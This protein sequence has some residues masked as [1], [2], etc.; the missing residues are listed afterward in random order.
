L[1]SGITG[2]EKGVDVYYAIAASNGN[3]TVT[4][5][6]ASTTYKTGFVS[7]WSAPAVDLTHAVATCDPGFASSIS[8]TV[9]AESNMAIATFSAD[10]GQIN[11]GTGPGSFHFDFYNTGPN[12]VSLNVDDVVVASSGTFTYTWYWSGSTTACT[13]AVPIGIK[14]STI[15]PTPFNMAAATRGTGLNP[16]PVS[17]S[18]PVTTGQLLI[19]GLTYSTAGSVSPNNGV[20]SITDT[21]GL[22]W[23][24]ILNSTITGG[25]KGVDIYYSIATTTGTDT[26]IIVPISTTY[27]SG[28]VSSWSASTVD[29]SHAFATCDAGFSTSITTTVT[30]NGP[31]TIGVISADDGQISSGT[32]TGSFHFD[33]YNGGPNGVSVNVDD[34]VEASSGTFTDIWSW[35]GSTTACTVAVPISK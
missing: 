8:T 27:K 17:V 16:D 23:I 18:L 5:T 35:S 12:H 14:G 21:E 33:F 34:A 10:D 1:N 30:T 29:V 9:T 11:S 6:P 31:A 7:T 20:A 22:T 19:A 26:L 28:F 4:L 13:V 3:E 32:G 24:H 15:L 2:G 25:D